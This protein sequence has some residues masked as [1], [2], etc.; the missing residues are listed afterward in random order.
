M[1]QLLSMS[2]STKGEKIDAKIFKK[3]TQ[4]TKGRVI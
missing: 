1:I 3:S 2:I 4:K